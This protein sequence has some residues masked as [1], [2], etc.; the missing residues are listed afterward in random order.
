VL[1]SVDAA[2]Q[3]LAEGY[4]PRLEEGDDDDEYDD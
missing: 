4:D 2:R 3:T 1:D